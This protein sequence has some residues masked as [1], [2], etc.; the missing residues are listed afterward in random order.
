M[1]RFSITPCSMVRWAQVNEGNNVPRSS[2]HSTLEKF[3]IP[4]SAFNPYPRTLFSDLSAR[5]SRLHSAFRTLGRTAYEC[6]HVRM[7]AHRIG[8][9]LRDSPR[10]FVLSY[11][12]TS[13]PLLI[14]HSAFRIE[15]VPSYALFRPLGSRLSPPGSAVHSAFGWSLRTPLRLSVLAVRHSAIRP[16]LKD[17]PVLPSPVLYGQMGVS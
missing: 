3:R 8:T 10:T 11:P 14:P 4:H 9:R 7:Y 2:G 6:T 15:S 5:G 13:F 17:A 1:P 16:K 12:R